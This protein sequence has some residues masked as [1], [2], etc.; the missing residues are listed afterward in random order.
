V[1]GQSNGMNGVWVKGVSFGENQGVNN[2]VVLH[3]ALHH[4]TAQKIIFGNTR[5]SSGSDLQLA[6]TD[7]FKLANHVI[8]KYNQAVE[9]KTASSYLQGIAAFAFNDPK[10][11]VSYGL[12][13][14][15]V[16]KFLKAAPGLHKKT[17]WSEFVDLIRKIIGLDASHYSALADLMEITHRIMSAKIS[18]S[19]T[20]TEKP[21]PADTKANTGIAP[22][23]K[24][25]TDVGEKLG[26]ARKD[27]VPSLEKVL[28]D[29]DIANEPFSKIWPA[30][31]IDAIEDAYMAA[32]AHVAREHVPSKPRV[33]SRLALWVEKVKMLR[34]LALK[35]VNGNITKEYFSDKLGE[36]RSL[37]DFRAKVTLLEAID[38]K[39]WKRI[40]EVTEH[41]NSYR[42]TEAGSKELSPYVNV[43]VDGKTQYFA[44]AKTVADVIEKVSSFLGDDA[45]E[46][47]IAFEVRGRGSSFSINK[48][49]DSEYR[50]L[51]TF[52]TANEASDF[53]KTNYAEVVKA[54]DAVK[55]GYNVKE[56]DVR[57]AENRA[58]TGADHR[59]GKDVN[60]DKFRDA[61]GFRGIEFGNWVTQGAN[62]KE[63]QG[64]INQAYDALMDLSD[65][66][67]V[68]PKALSLDG[69][70]GLGFGSRGSGAASAH[71]E[72]D[73]LVINLTKTRG[74][75]T[76][77]HEW[78]HALDNYFSRQ[79]GKPDKFEGNQQA[80]REQ[81][82]IT[83]RPEPMYVNKAG[84][85]GALTKARLEQLRKDNPKAGYLEPENWQIDP[86]HKDGV[87]PEVER[88]FADLVEALNKSPMASRARLIDKTREG[89]DGYW[90]R[91]IERA[92]R[93]FENYIIS[94]MM[95]NGYD[96]DYLANVREV[97]DFPRAKERYPYLLP[98]EVAPVAEAF[99]ALFSTIQTKESV[100]GGTVMF[101]KAGKTE[102]STGMTSAA[103]KAA[104][105]PITAK[106]DKS[107]APEI[108]IV[109]SAKDLPQNIQG[110][111]GFDGAVE[112][113]ISG[114][115]I[116]LVADRFSSVERVQSVLAHEAVGHYGIESIL[117]KDGFAQVSAQVVKMRDSGAMPE[118]FAEIASRYGTVDD[119]TLASEAIAVMAEKGLKNGSRHA[120]EATFR[121][122]AEDAFQDLVNDNFKFYKKVSED[123]EVS[124]EFFA[125]L[126]EWYIDRRKKSA[127]NGKKPN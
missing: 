19:T 126:F 43:K 31:E 54:W 111:K 102:K 59:K 1:I 50:K 113:A 27:K 90:S 18:K 53:I 89:Q 75:G 57:N 109:Q 56:A 91:I 26:G 3:E 44:G 119:A 96:N 63:R 71:F 120:V 49:G 86:K 25:V 115:K 20:A 22:G 37:T 100:S 4:V 14:P 127:P 97:Q 28:T 92:A 35:V 12:T 95:Q 114:N 51:K 116:Y 124:K 48:K 29:S 21:A 62:A 122:V 85:G 64:M 69:S 46:K 98:E 11:L 32:F 45:P 72:S 103:L 6:V 81:N 104:I 112:A 7:L 80:W 68:P 55:D 106:W 52:L 110:S 94:K 61:F 125:R 33:N 38:R 5:E 10:E 8:E 74:A 93:S 39:H 99:E 105:A 77:A 67:G 84:F 60:A 15:E 79:R 36:Y 107:A 87:R 78:F 41:A 2:E 65:I 23:D 82:F 13:D 108:V 101:S 34:G 17:A 16:Q 40:S 47:R 73:K 76:L 66:I 123:Y 24:V 58:R 88:S 121:Q 117:G 118:L 30:S 83:Y 9:G 42:Y 70:L